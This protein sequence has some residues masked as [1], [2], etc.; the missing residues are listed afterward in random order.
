MKNQK[1]DKQK[2][3]LHQKENPVQNDNLDQNIKSGP[4]KKTSNK[5]KYLDQD[6]KTGPKTKLLLT[7]KLNLQTNQKPFPASIPFD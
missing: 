3:N 1:L 6:L 7:Q 2:D 5:K 4:I